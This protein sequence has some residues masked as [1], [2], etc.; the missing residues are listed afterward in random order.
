M[1]DYPK[2]HVIRV[3]ELESFCPPKHVDTDSWVLIDRI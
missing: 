1:P 3:S 2:A